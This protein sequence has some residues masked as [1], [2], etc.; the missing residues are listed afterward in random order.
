M[1]AES[2][3]NNCSEVA[4]C[5]Q[6]VAPS[7]E[8][9]VVEIPVDEEQQRSSVPSSPATN[10]KKL[11]LKLQEM[12]PDHPLQEIADNKGHLLLLK[13][14]QR[15][16]EVIARHIESQESRCDGIKT[17]VFQ[18]SCLY[19]AFTWILLTLLFTAASPHSCHRWWVPCTW[20]FTT[21]MVI[22]STILHKLIVRRKALKRLQRDKADLRAVSKCIQELRMKG[23][24]FDL[25]KEP[26]TAKR[27]KSSSVE[28][29]LSLLRWCS[30]FF[31]PISLSLTSGLIICSTKY[32]AC[33]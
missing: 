1:I 5:E 27:M 9:H 6:T 17:E 4:V 16:E 20:S 8:C 22:I 2:A 7:P 19:F 30:E 12:A 18:L 26:H 24:S 33:S 31:V 15:E 29:K 32:I 13:L 3:A 11:N 21:S 28:N 10:C 23:V 14:W 25:S